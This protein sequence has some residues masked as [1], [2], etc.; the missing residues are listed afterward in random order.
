MPAATIRLQ[1]GTP[2]DTP[3]AGHVH[4]YAKANKKLYLKDDT[5][6]E[7]EISL[8]SAAASQLL[9]ENGDSLVTEDGNNI[10]LDGV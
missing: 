10:I 4:I 9:L 2:A 6:T 3:P 1:V 5:G 7:Y 8:I